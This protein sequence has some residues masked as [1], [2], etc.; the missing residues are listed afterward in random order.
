MKEQLAQL[1]ANFSRL[2]SFE[3]RFILVATVALALVLNFW[4]VIPHFSDLQKIENRF[5]AARK[6]QETFGKEIAQT[7]FYEKNIKDLQGEGVAIPQEEQTVNLLQAIQNQAAQSG[8]SILANNRQPERTNQ[9]FLERAQALTTQSGEPQLVDFLYNLGVGSSLIRVRALSIRPDPPR[10]ALSA[11]ITLIASYQKKTPKPATAP[12][13]TPATPPP[14]AAIK[15]A[16][17]PAALPA[18]KPTLKPATNAAAKP[19]TP[20]RK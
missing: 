18:A 11:N 6:K 20:L 15:P 12:A 14:A 13:A 3:R 2:S 16:P 1:S 7:A 10:M 9:F 19:S 17:A 8:V 5:G 4:L